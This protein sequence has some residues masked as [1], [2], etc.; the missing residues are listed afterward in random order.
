MKVMIFAAFK[1]K[2]QLNLFG[3]PSGAHRQNFRTRTKIT[4]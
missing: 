4:F 2:T 1:L 3:L